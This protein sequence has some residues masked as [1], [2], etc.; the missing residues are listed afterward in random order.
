VLLAAAT[1]LTGLV[2]GT[3]AVGGADSFGYLTEAEL[4]SRGTLHIDMPIA[5][6]APWPSALNTFAPPGYEPTY[7]DDR[8]ILV[9]TYAPGLPMLLAA[10]K[11]VAGFQAMF[12][13]VPALGGLL[14]FA[15]FQIGSRLASPAAGLIGAA[16][17]ATSPPVLYML[18]TTMT[19]VPVAALW[20]AAFWQ[21][22]G[23][24]RRHAVTAGALSAGAVLVRPNLLPISAVIALVLLRDSW[25]ARRH[26]ALIR[27]ALF[28]L[29]LLP[30]PI[31]IAVVNQA[32]YGSPLSSGYGRLSN[33]F[34]WSN[35]LPNTWRYAG[36]MIAAQTPLALVGTAVLFAP[37]RRLWP[38]A[39]DRATVIAGGTLVAIVWLSYALW[40]QFDA[41]WYLRFLLSAWPFIMVG[42]GAVLAALS[43]WHPSAMRPL[44]AVMLLLV[45][46]SQVR[47]AAAQ[48]TFDMWKGER[49]YVVAARMVRSSTEHNSIILAGAHA[50]SI[51]YYGG[52]M[53][54]Y[55]P[56]LDRDWLDW[57][58]AWCAAEGVHPYLVAE[59]WEIQDVKR[60]FAGQQTLARVDGPP[61]AIYA[62]PGHLFLFDLSPGAAAPAEP[63]R[64]TGTYRSPWAARPFP[65]PHVILPS[66]GAHP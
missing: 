25:T 4:W 8:W 64:V 63:T 5:A 35:V 20:A 27:A 58:V 59:D 34:T 62:E 3:R 56:R 13:V 48:S 16:L 6:V 21:A 42:A 7:R 29:A 52:R 43:R 41:W 19:D 1:T 57:A 11:L 32:L 14:V 50:G 22:L 37:W 18:L 49:R 2:Y 15:T 47:F 36:W 38:G 9:P 61:L 55:F 65:E 24:D 31:V 39:P 51:R 10:A 23:R 44:V 60:R 45:I 40:G 28:A 66:T 26:N 53:T 33:L 30:A 17:V 12:L 54:L 46:G